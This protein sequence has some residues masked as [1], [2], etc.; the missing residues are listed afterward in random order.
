[1]IFG[2]KSVFA[3]E[4]EIDDNEA[5]IG[6][7]CFHFPNGTLGDFTRWGY[8]IP[9]STK[10]ANIPSS[11]SL[12]KDTGL[13]KLSKEDAYK[14]MYKRVYEYTGEETN[15]QIAIDS[16]WYSRFTCLGGP[17]FDGYI[18]FLLADYKGYRFLWRERTGEI[19]ESIVPEH[20]FDATIYEF[21]AWCSITSGQD[22][23]LIKSPAYMNSYNKI[24]GQ[25]N[26]AKNQERKGRI[27][28]LKKQYKRQNNA[29]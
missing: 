15:E 23:K 8:M 9:N 20:I 26:R 5:F 27:Q 10:I 25:L 3:I 6:Y 22:I 16:F 2:D 18:P 21:A 19:I 7:C 17:M 1:M 4:C 29:E 11:F 12:R 28:E 13:A 14:E 24:Q